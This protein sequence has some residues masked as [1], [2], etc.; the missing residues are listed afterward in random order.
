MQ[1]QQLT[2]ERGNM[3][4][5]FEAESNALYEASKHVR[6]SLCIGMM[7]MVVVVVVVIMMMV[8]VIII[9]MLMLGL[10]P[11]LTPCACERAATT[12]RRCKTGSGSKQSQIAGGCTVPPVSLPRSP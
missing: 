3:S 7:M 8:M 9:I 4:Q 12:R 6:Q 1:E 5:Q 10:L 11:P 2:R